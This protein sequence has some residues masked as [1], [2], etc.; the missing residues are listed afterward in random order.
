MRCRFRVGHFHRY[1][2][3]PPLFGIS[4]EEVRAAV[5][6]CGD[7]STANEEFE[8]FSGFVDFHKLELLDCLPERFLTAQ[9]SFL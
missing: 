9:Y 4:V 1:H 3:Q 8:W 6:V 5:I 7:A 2:A